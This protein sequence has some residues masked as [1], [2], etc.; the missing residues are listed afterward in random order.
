MCN[1]KIVG[2]KDKSTLYKYKLNE[3]YLENSILLY[4]YLKPV[5]NVIKT[6]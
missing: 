2:G 5:K 1:N 3:N 4:T 6:A